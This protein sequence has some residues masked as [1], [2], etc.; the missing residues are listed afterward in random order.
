MIKLP[1]E[2]ISG[3]A[4]VEYIEKY[5]FPALKTERDRLEELAKWTRCD[6]AVPK[7]TARGDNAERKILQELSRKPWLGLMV[8]TFAQQLIVD[9]YRKSG[10]DEDAKG[11][12]TWQR[13]EMNKQQFGLNR[14]AI[15]FGYA[16]MK[17]T[18]GTDP[19]TGELMAAMKAVDPKNCLAIYEDPYQ[20]QWPVYALERQPNGEYWWW[21]EEQYVRLGFKLDKFE[22]IGEPVLHDYGL[23]PFVR[24]VNSMDLD[25]RCWGDVEPLVTCARELDKTRLDILLVQHHQSFMI[26]YGTGLQMP[27]G[28]NT[29]QEKMRI[30][31][32]TFMISANKDA[33]FGAIPASPLDGLIAAYKESLGQFLALAQLPPHVA[34]QIVNVAADALAAGTR[35]TMLKLAEKQAMFKAA[36]NQT[37]RLVNIIEGRKDDAQDIKFSIHWQDTT[38]Q[39]LAQFAD[40]WGKIVT[41][42]KVPAEGVWDMIPNVDQS[43]VDGWHAIYDSQPGGFAKYMRTMQEMGTAGKGGAAGMDPRGGP[44]TGQNSQK[45]NNKTGQPAS[46]NKSGR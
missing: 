31:Q 13:N 40:A 15:T 29:E 38:I 7:I 36:H 8:N 37:L 22:I 34:G 1:S 21:D 44:T 42:L 46:M 11:W 45:P 2:G 39:S 12:E 25:G 9:G 43:V 32:E 16:F 33:K 4:L 30:A 10:S 6:Q 23:V 14:A 27:D 24:Y 41:M 20:D 17:V 3:D 19:I 18:E 26:R 35:Q 5:V 28:E